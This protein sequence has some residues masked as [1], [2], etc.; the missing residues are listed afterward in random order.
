MNFIDELDESLTNSFNNNYLLEDNKNIFPFSLDESELPKIRDDKSSFPKNLFITKKTIKEKIKHQKLLLE[1]KRPSDKE[2]KEAYFDKKEDLKRRN[3]EAAQKSRDK[4]KLEFMQIIE[5]NK[6][7]KDEIDIINRKINLLCSGCKTIFDLKNDNNNEN[8]ICLSC[9]TD[10]VNSN[11]SYAEDGGKSGNHIS[12]NNIEEINNNIFNSSSIVSSF[13]NL[14]V[15]K[16]FNFIIIGLFALF[17]IFEL[18]S[19][20]PYNIDSK[21][22][23]NY[24]QIRNIE[25]I[26]FNDSFKV[27]NYYKN[28]SNNNINNISIIDHNFIIMGNNNMN[29]NINLNIDSNNGQNIKVNK[30]KNE[31]CEKDFF[32]SFQCQKKSFISKLDNSEDDEN[33]YN[34]YNEDNFNIDGKNVNLSYNNKNKNSIYFKLFVQS[35]SKDEGDINKTNSIT[36]NTHYTFSSDNT[37]CQDFYFFCKRTEN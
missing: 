12:T 36:D 33:N 31:V 11:L 25:Q 29:S 2:E 10:K 35:C 23:Q 13:T 26:K 14:K 32:T 15:Q 24:K 9:T 17:C 34:I 20:N 6:K 16:L 8:N 30:F 3:R 28:N 5:E 7:L 37:K 4:K 19:N 1:Q 18:V 21:N 27:N 22:R